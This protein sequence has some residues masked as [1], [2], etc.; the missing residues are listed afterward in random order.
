MYPPFFI[1]GRL[2][3]A[4]KVGDATLSL[5]GT[6]RSKPETGFE[7]WTPR[8]RATFALDFPDGTSFK[9]DSMQSG[10]GGFHSTVEIFETYLSFLEAAAESYK[11]HGM[12]GENSNLFPRHIVEWAADQP[13]LED[14]RCDLCDEDGNARTELIVE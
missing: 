8:S 12:E 1:S 5:L 3:P 2:A 10:M 13:Y 14:A 9:D 4:L 7:R 6:K 11:Y